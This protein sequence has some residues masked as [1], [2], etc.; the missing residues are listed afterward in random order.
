MMKTLLLGLCLCLGLALYFCGESL[1]ED[2]KPIA[3]PRPN[4]EAGMPLMAAI[5][6]RHTDRNFKMQALSDR[7]VAEILWVAVGV[8]RPDKGNLRTTPTAM[9]RQDVSVYALSGKGAFYYDAIEHSLDTITPG[10]QTSILGAPFGL[11]FVAPVDNP[12]AGVNVGHCSQNVYLYAASEGLNTVAK[13]TFDKAALKKLLKLSDNQ[14]I[15]LAQPIG[16]RP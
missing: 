4:T 3:L 14:Q 1:A 16:P 9:N 5:N 15:V 6:E 2:N 12:F 10:D 11:V 13:G 7:Q 8:N